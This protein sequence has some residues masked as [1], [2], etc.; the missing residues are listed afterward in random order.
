MLPWCVHSKSALVKILVLGLGAGRIG[1]ETQRYSF[2]V[3][4]PLP[5]YSTWIYWDDFLLIYQDWLANVDL[6]F[7]QVSL[8]TTV[9]VI[10]RPKNGELKHDPWANYEQWDDQSRN[11]PCWNLCDQL[12]TQPS[13]WKTGK[14]ENL[15]EVKNCIFLRSLQP[16]P[17]KCTY[18]GTWIIF[19]ACSSR[20]SSRYYRGIRRVKVAYPASEGKN[21]TTPGIGPLLTTRQ[22]KS[23]S[24][25]S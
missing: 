5:K 16:I 10:Q 11:Y 19:H 21:G 24:R 22:A 2:E 3:V 7:S 6:D 12:T 9:P 14:L 25:G 4:M 15:D 1:N 8:N 18:K 17:F 23:G 13:S 20:R